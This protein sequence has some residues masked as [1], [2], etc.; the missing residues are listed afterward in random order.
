MDN[1]KKIKSKSKTEKCLCCGKPFTIKRNPNQKYCSKRKCQLMRKNE[2]RK[3]KL[4]TDAD[5][6]SSQQLSNKRWRKKNPDY[7]R[8]YRQSHPKSVKKTGNGSGR[9]KNSKINSCYLQMR[10]VQGLQR[11]TR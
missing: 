3:N 4:R 7:W 9:R 8:K 11:A 1:I 6:Q 5:Y 2:W 10:R